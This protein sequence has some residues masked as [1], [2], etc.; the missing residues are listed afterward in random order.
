M[1]VPPVPFTP[2]QLAWLQG[3]L[4][5]AVMPNTNASD[6]PTTTASAVTEPPLLTQVRLLRFLDSF[7]GS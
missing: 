6:P 1:S 5:G 4:V 2:E 3:T 7:D